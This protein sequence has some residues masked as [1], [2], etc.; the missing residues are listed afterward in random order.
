VIVPPASSSG[1]AE[2]MNETANAVEAMAGTR[3][4]L[5]FFAF[6]VLQLFIC[7]FV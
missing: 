1:A 3:Y 2:A 4:R 6:M 5:Y 7:L